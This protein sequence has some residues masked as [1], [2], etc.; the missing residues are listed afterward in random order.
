MKKLLIIL[1]ITSFTRNTIAQK[2]NLDGIWKLT[3]TVKYGEQSRT[4][5]AY[6][7]FKD[8]GTIE[9][10]K[11]EIGTWQKNESKNIFSAEC[12]HFPSIN[13]DNIIETLDEKLLK[14]KNANGEIVSLQKIGLPKGEKLNNKY[15]GEWLLGKVEKDGESNFE[16][17]LINLNSK[18]IFYVQGYI[19]GEW[20]YN[21]K[22]KKLF[23]DVKEK[24]DP[25]NGKHSVLKSNKSA[26]TL[27]SKGAK[28]YFS[29][30][31]KEKI[32]KDN[33]VSGLT[34]SWEIENKTNSTICKS[35]T[36]EMTLSRY[37]NG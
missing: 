9:V 21:K 24:S 11:R 18:G 29:K 7:T 33:K 5:I 36:S 31:D 16:G 17:V 20:N 22:T 30:I 8:N 13:G 25:F 19:F 23:F 27:G 15:V 28:M 12:F 32:T 14:L 10:S 37:H 35:I 6:I 34:G 4:R 26:F 3:E 1:L 2:A